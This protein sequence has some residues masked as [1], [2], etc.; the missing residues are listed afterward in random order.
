MGQG[1]RGGDAC[2]AL[3]DAPPP[4]YQMLASSFRLPGQDPAWPA[5]PCR[6]RRS[7]AWLEVGA[8]V[9]LA[10]VLVAAAAVPG[11]RAPDDGPGGD[12][13]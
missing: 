8:L 11:E 3:Y 1:G 10:L 2:G 9:A 5:D 4:T 13:T 7:T 12:V 6:A